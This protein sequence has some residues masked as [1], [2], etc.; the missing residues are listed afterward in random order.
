VDVVQGPTS[1]LGQQ[2]LAGY[3][4][5]SEGD[6]KQVLELLDPDVEVRDRP[7]SPDAS[8]YHGLDGARTAFDTSIEMFEGFQLVPQAL[9]ETPTDIVVVLRMRGHGRESGV[10][11]DDRIAHHWTISDGRPL[12]LQ[13]YSDPDEA[14][15]A[16]GIER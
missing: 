10:P 12:R 9:Y 1:E 16:A 13:V 5:L 4:A 14:L 2:M 6:I 15:S 8:V 3:A 11:V 7:E